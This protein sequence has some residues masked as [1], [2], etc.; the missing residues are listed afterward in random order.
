MRRTA[1]LA[2]FVQP[3]TA[4][5]GR[6]VFARSTGGY[7][8]MRLLLALS[9]GLLGSACVGDAAGERTDERT[10][11]SAAAPLEVQPLVV[12]SCVSRCQ[13]AYSACLG[14]AQDETDVCLCHNGLVACEFPCGVHG[15]TKTCPIP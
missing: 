15:I 11:D 12:A 6:K 14:D 3:V 9:L 8:M 4:R 5:R 13:T 1:R 7:S 10:E 2:A